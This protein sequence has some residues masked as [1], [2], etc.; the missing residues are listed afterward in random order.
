M[1]EFA[2]THD[3][4]VSKDQYMEVI[5]AK[6]AVLIS[7]ACAC[8]AILSGASSAHRESLSQFGLH[9]GIAFQLIDDLL[10]YTSSE[11]V[12]GKPVGKDLREGKMT[13]PLIYTLSQFDGVDREKV[14]G[15]LSEEACQAL[16][17]RVRRDGA[18][19]RIREEAQEYVDRAANCLK[20]F[21]D[22]ETK[23]DLI[24]LSQHIIDREH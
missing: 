17:E 19:E 18:L 2:H 10:D 21:P 8:G 23:R 13:L 22:S 4:D 5:T 9:C 11:G 14:R 1:I 7:A 6:T 24:R 20:I 3:W 12:F 15:R 16:I